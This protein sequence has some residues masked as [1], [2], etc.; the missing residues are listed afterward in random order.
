LGVQQ[1]AHVNP[2]GFI[3][4]Q[5]ESLRFMPKN[6]AKQLACAHHFLV[7]HANL[8]SPLQ[9]VNGDSHSS[10]HQFFLDD[11]TNSFP[12][13]ACEATAN[14][15]H[16]NGST[17]FLS[18]GGNALKPFANCLVP[19]RRN[20]ADGVQIPLADQIRDPKILAHVNKLHLAER[21][22]LRVFAPMPGSIAFFGLRPS[23]RYC[24][25]K[26]AA[27]AADVITNVYDDFWPFANGL[28]CISDYILNAHK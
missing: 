6:Q 15:R 20:S 22:R 4:L 18:F 16:V 23:F 17:E 19:H 2:A 25:D 9:I 26:T 12:L 28:C 8:S 21:E 7:G 11:C 1:L 13:S 24:H 5:A 14:S 27:P 3:E 10:V